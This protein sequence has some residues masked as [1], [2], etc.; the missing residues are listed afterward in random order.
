MSHVKNLFLLLSCVFIA[1]ASLGQTDAAK[2]KQ[3]VATVDGQTIYD[4]DLAASVQGQ[5]LPL[6]NQEYEIKKKALDDLIEQKLLEAAAKKKG[7]TTQE[8]LVQ[9]VDSKASDPSDTEIEGYYLAQRERLNRPLD[10]ALK[11]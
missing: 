7:L 5:L 4:E 3:P 9:E 1:A 2:A 11:N 8:L 6:R 10:D